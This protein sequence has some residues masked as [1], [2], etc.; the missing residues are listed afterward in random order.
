MNDLH[1][2]LTLA[3]VHF[4]ALLSPGPDFALVVQNASRY[5]RKTGFY[6]ALGL[7]FG[8]LTHSILSMTGVSYLIHL[9]PTLFS[10]VRF[11]GGSYLLY[12]GLIALYG[13]IRYWHSSNT[14]ANMSVQSATSSRRIAFTRGYVTNL[15][16][17]KA[18]VF[19]VSLLSSLIPSDM[20]LPSKGAALVILWS[21]S[22][23][24]FG[25][26]AWLLSTAKLQQKLHK[27]AKYIDGLCG[28]LFTSLGTLILYI[29]I[30]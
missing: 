5:G 25:L 1:A 14:Q 30:I 29:S 4:I 18:L 3:T 20:S 19:F 6:I 13:T 12:L 22:L 27:V 15:L 21:L 26:L 7:S 16:N 10:L 23:G 17:P 8:I 9:H 24:W 2:L 28:L 11:A